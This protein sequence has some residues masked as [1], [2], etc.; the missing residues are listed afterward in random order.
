MTQPINLLKNLLPQALSLG[1]VEIQMPR[2][3]LQV[4]L[5]TNRLEVSNLGGLIRLVIQGLIETKVFSTRVL[6]TKDTF[7]VQTNTLACLEL[8]ISGHLTR[9][10]NTM[11]IT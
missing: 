2:F 10:T 9:T 3:I 11:G 8:E 1:L 7:L 5:E 6:I 4:L